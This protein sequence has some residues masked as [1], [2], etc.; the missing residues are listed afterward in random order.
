[1]AKNSGYV[2]RANPTRS[3]P[4]A[5]P[6]RGIV[7]EANPRIEV[8]V[9]RDADWQEWQARVYVN[10]KEYKPASYHTNDR[11]DANTTAFT[12][13]ASMKANTK[14][15]NLPSRFMAGARAN[16]SKKRRKKIAKKYGKATAR[17]VKKGWLTVRGNP[18]KLVEVPQEDVYAFFDGR[19]S[20]QEFRYGKKKSKAK[21]KAKKAAASKRTKCKSCGKS[22]PKNNF[23]IFCGAAM[24]SSKRRAAKKRKN[25]ITTKGAKRRLHPERCPKPLASKLLR[26]RKTAIKRHAKRPKRYGN[27]AVPSAQ[28][29]L[30]YGSK[31]R[32]SAFKSGRSRNVTK[33]VKGERRAKSFG[34]FT[35]ALSFLA[36]G[37]KSWVDWWYL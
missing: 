5:K 24:K 18:A 15:H 19:K 7:R 20:L 21:P 2:P 12:M 36:P 9:V 13:V 1:M 35:K 27:C 32:K 4:R 14:T 25:P 31:G 3:N 17:A 29:A 34:G 8:K 16:P 22:V 30:R 37:G 28:Y 11:E 6:Y 33:R 26:D 23:C 10:R